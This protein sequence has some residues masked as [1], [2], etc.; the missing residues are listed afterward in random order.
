[1][2]VAAERHADS[3]AKDLHGRAGGAARGGRRPQD[4]VLAGALH[5]ESAPG[6]GPQG[7][8]RRPPRPRATRVARRGR[9]ADSERPRGGDP[10]RR[11]RRHHKGLHERDVEA[12]GGREVVGRIVL[13]RRRRGL[14]LPVSVRSTDGRI[15]VRSMRRGS[16]R[17]GARLEHRGRHVPVAASIRVPVGSRVGRRHFEQGPVPALRRREGR[18]LRSRHEADRHRSIQGP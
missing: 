12:S 9:P 7:Q 13:L 6:N 4:P 2:C 18:E 14:H 3:H 17:R 8:R 5:S 11:Q 10:D 15:D 1:M 16:E